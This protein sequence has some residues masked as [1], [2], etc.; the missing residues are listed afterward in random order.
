MMTG[1]VIK[2]QDTF[3]NIL[4]TKVAKN[5]FSIDNVV[6]NHHLPHD[7][8]SKVLNAKEKY[9]S[10]NKKLYA[11]RSDMNTQEIRKG[12]QKK[13]EDSIPPEDKRN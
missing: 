6:R 2:E 7:L 13:I 11:L 3:T 4:P 12:F 9:K 1:D 10:D 8:S 5:I